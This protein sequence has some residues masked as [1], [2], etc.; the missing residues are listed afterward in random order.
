MNIN[1]KYKYPSISFRKEIPFYINK[2]DEDYSRDPYE[3]YYEYVLPSTYKHLNE[4]IIQ[5]SGLLGLYSTMLEMI[6][7]KAPESV[8]ELGCGIGF[9]SHLLKGKFEETP[10]TGLDYSYQMIKMAH[11]L[12]LSHKLLELNLE[13]KGFTKMEFQSKKS[14]G[15]LEFIVGDA[16]D[17][18]FREEVFDLVMSSFLIDRVSDPLKLFNEIHGV[19]KKGGQ[20][21]FANPLNYKQTSFWKD[22]YPVSKL[23]LALERIGFQLDK[24]LEEE[25][26]IPMDGR[27]NAICYNVHI[28][29]LI[30]K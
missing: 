5:N 20:Y 13:S 1:H 28:C 23:Q 15:D 22:F 4:L 30:K 7:L 25:V 26:R 27:G 2:S 18:P 12:W 10:V 16:L 8:L 21:I 29:S 24:T 6:V 11:D 9:L 14:Y 17:L 19:L 3:K